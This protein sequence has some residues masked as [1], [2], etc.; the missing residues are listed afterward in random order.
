M[1]VFQSPEI[2]IGLSLAVIG[3][4]VAVTTAASLLRTR[5]LDASAVA[6]DR[7]LEQSDG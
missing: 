7:E 4:T 3:V 1:T 6:D 2:G 5:S